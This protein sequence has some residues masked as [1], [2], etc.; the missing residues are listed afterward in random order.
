MLFIVF[1]YISHGNKIRSI[2]SG[3]MG[4][5]MKLIHA[6]LLTTVLLSLFTACAIIN[7]ES[8]S[9][10]Y[11]PE[12]TISASSDA[13]WGSVLYGE[14]YR[15]VNNVWNK[16]ASTGGFSQ[17]VFIEDIAGAQG[18]GW[19][20]DWRNGGYNVVAYPEVIFGDKPWDASSG[21]STAFPVQAGSA[22]ITVDFDLT[23]RATGTYNMAFSLWCVSALPSGVDT[24]S[25]E[26]MIW[27]LNNGMTPAGTKYSTVTL[28]GI[29]YD[30]YMKKNH[31]DDSGG[32][33]HNWT[34]VAFKA[35]ESITK[36]PLKISDFVDYLLAQKI[37]TP[38]NYVTSVELGNEIVTGS[39][40]VDA[41]AYAISVTP[42]PTTP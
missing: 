33:A 1:I 9:E 8:S 39:G 18:F 38:S 7:G 2:L 10:V 41:R 30:V 26:I 34:Y 3:D 21:I 16:G 28:G 5:S 31:G 14:Q 23:V 35:R 36:G 32:S 20:W 19:Q 11:P 37:L 27:N 6:F 24:I 40:T 13:D 12:G 15:V 29:A 25:H 22:D 4:D 17:C 42:R